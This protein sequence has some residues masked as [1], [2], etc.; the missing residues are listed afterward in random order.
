VIDHVLACR[1]GNAT[2]RLTPA[3]VLDALNVTL[4]V[5]HALT[6]EQSSPS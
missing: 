1:E 5:H 6:A 2:S 4:D 3:S